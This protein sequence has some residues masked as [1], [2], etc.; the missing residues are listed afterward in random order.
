M[1]NIKR[2]LKLTDDALEGYIADLKGY[3]Y[4]INRDREVLLDLI[5]TFWEDDLCHGNIIKVG[6]VNVLSYSKVKAA[7]VAASSNS[8]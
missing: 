7:L 2:C 8:S 6:H 4:I 5:E 3:D 1:S